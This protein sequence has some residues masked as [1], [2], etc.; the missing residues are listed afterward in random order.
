MSC[1]FSVEDL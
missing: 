1:L